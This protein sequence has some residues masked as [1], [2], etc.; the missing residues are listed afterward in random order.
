MYAR[1][2]EEACEAAERAARQCQPQPMVVGTPSTPLGNDLDPSK[3][4]YVCRE[5]L[6]G[7]A[8]VAF[9]GNTG[10]ARWCKKK[11]LTSKRYP[12]GLMIWVNGFGQSYERKMAYARAFAEV[13]RKHGIKAWAEGRLD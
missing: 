5:G 7:F 1:I 11:G 13:L 6:C 9:P 12:K 3:P 4:I 2:Y 10:W 8:W